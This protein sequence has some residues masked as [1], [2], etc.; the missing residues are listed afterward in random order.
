MPFTADSVAAQQVQD[1]LKSLYQLVHDIEKKRVQSEQ[2]INA[3]NKFNNSQEEKSQHYQ[4]CY[5]KLFILIITQLETNF[6]YRFY[7]TMVFKYF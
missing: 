4:V 1:C 5:V 7:F 2:G 6:F 3:I